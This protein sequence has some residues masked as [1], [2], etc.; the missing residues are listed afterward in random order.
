[1]LYTLGSSEVT[2]PDS[3]SKIKLHSDIENKKKK[4]PSA[5]PVDANIALQ[6]KTGTKLSFHFAQLLS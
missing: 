4:K 5:W 2:L 1:M 6:K 3:L